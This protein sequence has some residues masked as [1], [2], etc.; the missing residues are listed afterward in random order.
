VGVSGRDRIAGVGPSGTSLLH[1]LAKGGLHVSFG[2]GSGR[3]GGG[4][5]EQCGALCK[6]ITHVQGIT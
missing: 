4:Q 5:G 3:F 6:L 1:S 2:R